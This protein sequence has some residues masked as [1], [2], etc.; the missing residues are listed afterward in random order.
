MKKLLNNGWEFLKLPSGSTME[1]ARSAGGW[2]KVDIP[3]DWLIW[4][5]RDLYES[6]DAWYRR[7]LCIP[8]LPECCLLVFDGVYMD[9]DVLLNGVKICSH[10][11]GYTAF[12]AD[13][14]GKLLPV[15]ITWSSPWTMGGDI[16]GS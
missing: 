11:Y 16:V 2:E 8:E 3:H 5:H 10:A 13:L 12:Q 15:K 14:T 6:A 9:C 1:E 4:Q 7:I